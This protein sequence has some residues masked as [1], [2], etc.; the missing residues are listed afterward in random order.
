MIAFI[1]IC[2][3]CLYLLIF[4]KLGLLKKTVG[5][6]SAFA[7]V[8]VVLIGGIVFMWYTF[9]PISSDARMFRYV[10]PIVPNVKGH[11]L[12]VP[13]EGGQFL[14]R[15]DTLFRIDP[16]PFEITVRQLQAQVRQFEA[17]H[18]LAEVNV[19]R[20]RDLLKVQAAAQVDLDIW[21]ANRDA[22][23]AGIDSSSAQLD[24]ALWQLEETTVTAPFDGHV[25]N[26]QL[27]PGN[28]VTSVPLASPMSF[29]SDEASPVV[30][31]FSQ[32]A[33][34]RI[35]PGDEA[36]VVFTRVPGQTFSG[37]VVKIIPFGASSQLSAS[38]QLPE[39]TGVPAS[40]RWA[41]KLELDDDE[42]ARK[43]PQGAGGTV[44]IYTSAGKPVH[45]ISKVAMRMSAWL[46]YLT[47]P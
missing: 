27:R 43:L 10:I 42:A 14:Q 17:E 7:G 15:G 40:D 24:N 34:R 18:Q 16:E 6:I 20:A 8:G 32:S 29:I 33:I 35:A 44:A 26:L 12:E 23:Q 31:S 13:I 47:S 5:N 21:T 39:M 9:S 11:V 19:K 2:Y 25:V 45:V 46:A 22:A 3:A 38:G 28:M 4:N 30:V 37:K 36:D 41:V 1:T